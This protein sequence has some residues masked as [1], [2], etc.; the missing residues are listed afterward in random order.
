MTL[1]H[2]HVLAAAGLAIA[3]SVAGQ[4]QGQGIVFSND[5][6]D[7]A[8]GTY[9]VS[10]LNADW[11]NPPSESG[12]AQGRGT[13]VDGAAAFGGGRSLR[14]LYPQDSVGPSDNTGGGA[15]WRMDLGQ[16]YDELY[17]SYRIRFGA[18]FDFVRGGK[19]PGL[20]GGTGNTGGNVPD[21][22]D[23]WS[24]R[25]MWRT[26]GSGGSATTRDA[27]NA[28]QYVYH[29]DQ[30]DTFGEDFRWDDGPDDEWVEFEDDRWY[31]FE[32]RVL[33]NTPGEN[34]GEIQAWLDGEQVLDVQGL[35]FRDVSTF[36]IDELLF[37][38]FFGGSSDIWAPSKDEFVYYDDFVVSTEP[39]VVPEP[40][41]LALGLAVAGFGMVRRRRG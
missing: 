36:G 37:S 9:T 1:R 30:P 41:T 16:S 38:T 27:A 2:Q 10:N 25:M 19:L 6:D 3:S 23:G 18:G 29:P 26:D 20:A 22:T 40:S 34:D 32:H 4:G 17:L 24:A 21:G 14:V 39:I 8:V 33:M 11:N 12:I 7:D 28:V 13:V 5:F 35:R 15:Q 31:Q